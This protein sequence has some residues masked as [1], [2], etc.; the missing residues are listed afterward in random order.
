MTSSR[1]K[2][3]LHRP[4]FPDPQLSINIDKQFDTSGCRKKPAWVK[5]ELCWEACGP[6][7][8]AYNTL[9]PAVWR[10]LKNKCTD[11]P[12]EVRLIVKVYMIGLDLS[13][14]AP[15][16]VFVC[17]NEYAA[18]EAKNVVKADGILKEYPG[19]KTALM[20]ILPSGDLVEVAD[21]P[22]SR[23]QD[24][25][26]NDRR[27]K[28]YFDMNGPVDTIAMPIFIKHPI[29]PLRKATANLGFDSSKLLYLFTA[30]HAFQAAEPPTDTM[31]G[32]G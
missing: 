10:T 28:V 8:D 29:A 25:S 16:L 21:S 5:G 6:A 11:D 18:K 26:Q 2:I 14:A 15:V 31:V 23:F 7:L 27:P 1:L 9:L 24:D 12:D 20:D 32:W 3:T 4:R 13:T 22:K 30:A 17:K 19:F